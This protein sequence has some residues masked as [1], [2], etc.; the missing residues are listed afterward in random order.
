MLLEILLLL[1][2]L[3]YAT[4]IPFFNNVFMFAKATIET[5]RNN[6]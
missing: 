5:N 1:R 4:V 6:K 2:H 3:E